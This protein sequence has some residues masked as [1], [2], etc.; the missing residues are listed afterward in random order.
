MQEGLAS[1]LVV[2]GSAT[3]GTEE[4][5]LDG[6]NGLIFPAEDFLTLRDKIELLIDD[7]LLLRRLAERGQKTAKEKFD[8]VRM[9]DDL[10]AYLSRIVNEES[11]LN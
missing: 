8:I 2:I 3:G 6:E 9:V 10:E 4:I 5:I 7:P 11:L 1:G